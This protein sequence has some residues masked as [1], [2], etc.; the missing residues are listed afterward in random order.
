LTRRRANSINVLVAMFNKRLD[1]IR[2]AIRLADQMAK[3]R[4]GPHQTYLEVP[5]FSLSVTH[6]IVQYVQRKISWSQGE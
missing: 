3:T 1:Q 5:C 4:I 6:S 2:C